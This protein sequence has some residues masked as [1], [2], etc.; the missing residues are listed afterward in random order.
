MLRGAAAWRRGPRPQWGLRQV[1]VE[2][3]ET[4]TVE[5]VLDD[6]ASPTGPGRGDRDEVAARASHVPMTRTAGD[7]ECPRLAVD[8]GRYELHSAGRGGNPP[9][10]GGGGRYRPGM[11]FAPGQVVT[12]FSPRLR[13]DAGQGYADTAAEMVRL[14]TAMPG[15][16]EVKSF[17]ADDGERVTIATFADDAAER[18]WRDHPDHRRAAGRP[19]PVLRRVQHQV[20]TTVRTSR[21]PP[22]GDASGPDRLAATAGED[23]GR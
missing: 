8:P 15:F 22:R 7:A 14:A 20:C 18:A 6:R 16:V 10:A 17:V 5:L 3:G 9:G 11:T 19:R 12:V 21:F 23:D 4:A 2:P 13:P 1:W